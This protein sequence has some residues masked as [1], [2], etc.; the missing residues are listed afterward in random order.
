MSLTLE[1][2]LA[3]IRY[4][5]RTLRRDAGF[6]IVAVTI[7]ALGIGANVAVF[8][9]V[10]TILLRPLPF[11]EP[12]QLVWIAPPGSVSISG[13]TYSA[14][15]YEELVARNRSFDGLTGYFAFSTAE[16][17][18]L[19]GHGEPIPLTGIMVIGNFFQMLG[20]QPEMGRLF[21]EDEKR[22][23]SRAVT[24][25]TDAFW[26]RRLAA[27]P[28][29]IGKGIDLNGTPTSVIGV[30]PASFDFGAV[31][32]PGSKVDI[33]TPAILDDI[34]DEG[35]TVTLIARLKPNV[36]ISSAQAEAQIL[37]P[38]LYFNPKYPESKG[39]YKLNLTPLKEHVSGKLRRSLVILWLAVGAIL[40]IVC[41]NLSNLL[42]VRAVGRAQELAIRSALG[43]V[44]GR[45]MVQLLTESFLLAWCSALVGLGLALVTTRF[46]AHQGSIALPLLASIAIDR[47]ALVWSVLI[48]SLAAVLFGVTPSIRMVSGNLFDSLKSSG[49]RA[50]HDRR[51]EHLRS[52]LIVAEVAMAAVLLVSAGLL[53][54]SFLR[55]LDVDLGF[56]PTRAAALKLDYD[57]GGSPDQRGSLFREIVTRAESLPGVEAAGIVDYLPLGQNRSWG[58]PTAKGKTYRRGELPSALVYVV[59]PG[60]FRAMG[61]RLRGRDFSWSDTP[62]S[63][64]VMVMSENAARYLWPGEDAVGKMAVVNGRDTRVIGVVADVHQS[65]VE[66]APA[67]Q[68][69]F[70]AMQ[71]GTNGAELVVRTN[72]PP[73]VLSTP[74]LKALRKMNPNQPASKFRLI[75]TIV[76]R[77][78]SPR[79]FFMV[80]VTCFAALGLTLA[81][82]GI[83][84][85]ISYSVSERTQEIGIRMALGA[86]DS[87]VRL[88]VIR[89]AL[90]LVAIGVAI[91]LIASL[92]AARAMTSMLFGTKATDLA[93]FVSMV[94]VLG[95]VA[96]LAS[97]IPARRASRIEPMVALRTE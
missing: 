27:D 66:G 11:P 71:E 90:S 96:L 45:L 68:S 78:V 50:T 12:R 37:A 7:L 54:R 25:V 76:E 89:R 5:L 92:A 61:M 42:L 85:V 43:A 95:A 91:G 23:N 58:S 60:Y 48:A 13:E 55:V 88:E 16:N 32:A 87:R 6:T 65:K 83:Y 2:I 31:F 30:L 4:G 41:V 63:E 69:Y 53:L 24:I 36:P 51:H 70:S 15:A 75:Q 72:T 47:A 64:H 56:Q 21:T 77:A 20:V 46:L 82:L 33:F 79:R 84:G 81:A 26:R 59:S 94:A 62:K 18:R 29:I 10:N 73:A 1:T 44:R 3:D 8:S 40:L 28:E 57:D 9:V 34:R 74:L 38:E 93:T 97:Y 22:K 80:L 14:Y 17:Y 39:F 67:W 49:Q 35:N 86:T 19:T 52:T